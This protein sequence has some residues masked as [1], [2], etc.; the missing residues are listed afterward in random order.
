MRPYPLFK[1]ADLSQTDELAGVKARIKALTERTV[2]RGCTEAE[3]MAAAEMASSTREVDSARGHT[4]V[5]GHRLAACH[6]LVRLADDHPLV[7]TCAC[8]ASARSD[9][10]GWP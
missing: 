3:A 1:E 5:N 9:G 6:P 10:Q 2:A 7:P 8:T 4:H